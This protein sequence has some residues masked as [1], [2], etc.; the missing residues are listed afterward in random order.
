MVF[1]HT[2]LVLAWV[3]LKEELD[4]RACVQIGHL[5]GDPR[6]EEREI[7]ESKTT[8][9]GNTRLWETGLD[10]SQGPPEKPT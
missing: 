5:G 4:T 9:E 8:K 10:S 7:R 6:K 2:L 3:S 1:I